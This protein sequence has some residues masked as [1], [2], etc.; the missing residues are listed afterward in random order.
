M[1]AP[2]A[3]DAPLG[4]IVAA[5]EHRS[6]LVECFQPDG[7]ACTITPV[8]RLKGILSQAHNRFIEELNRHTLAECALPLQT[9]TI[10]GNDI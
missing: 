8:C 1:L 10:H 5:L 3:L 6:A 7:G 4:D 9:G 2:T